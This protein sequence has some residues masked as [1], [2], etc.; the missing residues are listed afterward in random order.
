[1]KNSVNR[2]QI[3]LKEMESP[4]N[5]RHVYPHPYREVGRDPWGN[6]ITENAEEIDAENDYIASHN[7]CKGDE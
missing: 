5:V 2:Q 3:S 4:Y 7:S 6:S 1:M